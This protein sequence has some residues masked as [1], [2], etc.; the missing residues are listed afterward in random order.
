MPALLTIPAQTKYLGI[1]GRYPSFTIY[2]GDEFRAL[3]TCQQSDTICAVDFSLGYY[4]GS[5]GYHGKPN[6]LSPN[7]IPNPEEGYYELIIPLDLLAGQTVDFVLTV[8]DQGI[9][10]GDK[11]L[12]IYPYIY[13]N[14]DATP[15][16]ALPTPAVTQAS[17]NQTPVKTEDKTPGVIYGSI[18]YGSAPGNIDPNRA[19]AVVF[20][21]QDDQTWW[22]VHTSINHPSFQM[23]VSPG[24]YKVLAYVATSGGGM[25]TVGHT[26]TT[27]SCGQSLKLVKVEP[28]GR[29]YN[30]ALGDWCSSGDR[31]SKP[32]AVPLP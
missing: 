31:P 11:A 5:G 28:N 7:D 15:A 30:L 6:P 12:W 1:F 29:V 22:W 10:R 2:P 21:N 18:D 4:D 13:R 19:G 3:L 24:R 14:P 25:T 20:F 17:A 32:K 16:A 23:T 9:R 27:G 8:R 26:G